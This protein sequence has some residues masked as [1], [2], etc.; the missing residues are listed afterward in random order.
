MAEKLEGLSSLFPCNVI[1]TRLLPLNNSP[2]VPLVLYF[3]PFSSICYRAIDM[4]FTTNEN[5]NVSQI[6]NA[7][8]VVFEGIMS[9]GALC[10]TCTNGVRMKKPSAMALDY[11]EREAYK[12]APP[13][14]KYVTT[15]Y[16][17]WTDEEAGVLARGAY[18]VD[19]STGLGTWGDATVCDCICILYRSCRSCGAR[20][21]WG[22]QYLCFS[23]CCSSSHRMK[24]RRIVR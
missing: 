7:P 3:D 15:V 14:V 4:D 19:T 8:K 17:Y 21:T 22:R 23:I 16:M 18:T 11:R 6:Y 9:Y 13:F 1:S 24:M 12:D 5:Q 2:S 20:H 10:A